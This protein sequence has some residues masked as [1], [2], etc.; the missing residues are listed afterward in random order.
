MRRHVAPLIF[1]QSL[2]LLSQLVHA[3]SITTCYGET[4]SIGC[5]EDSFI[6][7]NFAAF[8]VFGTSD[9]CSAQSTAECWVDSTYFVSAIC[10]GHH[11][12]QSKVQYSHDLSSKSLR[13]KCAG[14]V[15]L[16]APR[17]FVQYLCII[18]TLLS[19]IQ[20]VRSLDAD[21]VGGFLAT[22]DYQL[23]VKTPEW[24]TDL[25]EEYCT[26]WNLP[27]VISIPAPQGGLGIVIKLRDIGE[28][29]RPLSTHTHRYRFAHVEEKLDPKNRCI[30]SISIHEDAQ[31]TV[32]R[33]TLVRENPIDN[34]RP[35]SARRKQL[36]CRLLPS[37]LLLRAIKRR[38]G[39]RKGGWMSCNKGVW[40][41]KCLG[42]RSVGTPCLSDY[43]RMDV[44][45]TATQHR[46]RLEVCPYASSDGWGALITNEY[47]Q[48]PEKV[49]DEDE[50]YYGFASAV[51]GTS[52]LVFGPAY[53]FTSIDFEVNL[54]LGGAVDHTSGGNATSIMRHGWVKGLLFEYILLYCPPLPDVL[55]VGGHLGYALHT[56]TDATGATVAVAEIGCLPDRFVFP[57]STVAA[58]STSLHLSDFEPLKNRLVLQCDHHRRQWIPDPPPGGCMTREEINAVL[59]ALLNSKT[60][61]IAPPDTTEAVKETI[62]T[63]NLTTTA[64]TTNTTVAAMTMPSTTSEASV[65]TDPLKSPSKIDRSNSSAA[66]NASLSHGSSAAMGAIFGFI[67]CLLILLIVVFIFRQRLLRTVRSKLVTSNTLPGRFPGSGMFM[68]TLSGSLTFSRHRKNP[69]FSPSRHPTVIMSQSAVSIPHH[70]QHWLNGSSISVVKPTSAAVSLGNLHA[71][72]PSLSRL[73]PPSI[74]STQA[75]SAVQD[76]QQQPGPPSSVTTPNSTSLSTQRQTLLSADT[77]TT[78]V[79]AGQPSP[80]ITMGYC[81]ASADRLAEGFTET[82]DVNQVFSATLPWKSKP[83]GGVAGGLKRLSTF[84]R[85]AMSGSSASFNGHHSNHGNHHQ[86]TMATPGAARRKNFAGPWPSASFASSPTSTANSVGLFSSAQ[87]RSSYTSDVTIQPIPSPLGSLGRSSLGQIPVDRKAPVYLVDSSMCHLNNQQ[88]EATTPTNV[89]NATLGGGARRGMRKTTPLPP[90]PPLHPHYFNTNQQQNQQLHKQ[91]QESNSL[92]GQ[93]PHGKTATL[94]MDTYLEPIDGVDSLG[95]S[96]TI[97]AAEDLSVTEVISGGTFSE[98]GMSHGSVPEGTFIMLRLSARLAGEARDQKDHDEV[99]KRPY[100]QNTELNEQ[101]KYYAAP[102]FFQA[103][104]MANLPRQPSQRSQCY[105]KNTNKPATTVIEVVHNQDDV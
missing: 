77:V 27:S 16:T 48:Q 99:L 14:V 59:K 47:L 45:T 53:N 11:F 97:P 92:S 35:P 102:L 105:D 32:A 69:Y 25:S 12:C 5:S 86:Q 3:E 54:Q 55:E 66:E 46:L 63:T 75:A 78:N 28:L 74:S 36:S 37:L 9:K 80:T 70:P 73:P 2:L 57:F 65:L 101:S 52:V 91:Q 50:T 84:I 20:D 98:V 41:Y 94:N 49:E 90:L 22:H 72:K 7:V 23:S 68:N 56:H 18:S 10:T 100:N 34:Y 83:Q 30:F 89:A 15:E 39:E 88:R 61:T 103:L 40:G 87:S 71:S 79:S 24:K 51:P 42:L 38:R 21:H 95:R 4:L 93:G 60:T 1:I 85:S 13:Y 64:T 33:S 8:G 31:S 29:Y 82:P 44:T 58:T 67:L 96:D 6:L 17:L 43:L 19:S 26:Q 104:H 76:A 81:G 62:K